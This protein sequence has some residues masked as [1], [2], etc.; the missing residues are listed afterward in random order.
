MLNASVAEVPNAPITADQIAEQVYAVSHGQLLQSSSS[1]RNNKDIAMVV[2]RAPI[3]RRKPGRMPTLNTFETFGKSK[4]ADPEIESLQ[5]AIITSG[6][7]KGTGILYVNYADKSKGGVMSIWLP[8]LRK[9][10]RMNEP[11]HDDNWIGTNLTYGELVL[12]KPEH[13]IHELLGE[14]T[15]QDCLPAMKLEKW[16]INRYT[17]KLPE[18]QCEHQGKAVYRLKST[19]R[20]KNWWYDYHISDIDKQTFALYRTVYFKNDEKIKTVVVDW[21]SLNQPDPR[22]V[23]PR[24][25]YALSHEDGSDT[26]V[27]VPESTIQLNPDLPDEFWSEETLKKHGR[28]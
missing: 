12:R 2:T 9:I 18:P 14:S 5:M 24:Y 25:I 6:K 3:D 11:A 27:Y 28:K 13:E 7:V 26:M 17:K 4:P 10:R 21:Q 16:E 8:A 23:F 22:L 1:T 15:L 19:T 20:F